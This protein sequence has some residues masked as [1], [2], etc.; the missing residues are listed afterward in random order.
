M[1]RRDPPDLTAREVERLT[2]RDMVNLMGGG[3]EGLT[4]KMLFL[5]LGLAT[6]V[7]PA[8]AQDGHIPGL[9]KPTDCVMTRIKSIH[10]RLEGSSPRESGAAVEYENGAYGV[11]YQLG[12]NPDK[13][14]PGYSDYWQQKTYEDNIV[15]SR[16]GDPI[17]LCL[18]SI[19][20][21]LPQR[22]WAWT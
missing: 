17:K 13:G 8:C 12:D 5:V 4:M 21:A 20:L 3:Q 14:Q 19:S 11:Q 16:V 15:A 6:I 10:G 18:V 2:T 9:D 7:D 22:G 1:P